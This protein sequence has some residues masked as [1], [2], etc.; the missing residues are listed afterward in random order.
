MLHAQLVVVDDE[1]ALAGSANLDGRSLLI[2]YELM[3]AFHDRD[4][5]AAFTRW[6]DRERAS[7]S[8]CTPQGAGLGSDLLEGLLLWV[9][10]Q[11]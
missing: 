2:N 7:A 11:L 5:I 3:M 4:A 8:I 1:L 9:G 6:F 10:F